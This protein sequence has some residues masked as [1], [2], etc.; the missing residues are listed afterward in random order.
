[1]EGAVRSGSSGHGD[2]HGSSG[3]QRIPQPQSPSHDPEQEIISGGPGA[4]NIDHAAAAAA[5]PGSNSRGMWSIT[6]KTTKEK[7]KKR[8]CCGVRDEKQVEEELVLKA[9]KRRMPDGSDGY[10]LGGGAACAA[11][12]LPASPPP[13][14][15][16]V[17]YYRL[18]SHADALD[19]ALM[20]LG[21]LAAAA[22]GI[23]MPVFLVYLGKLIDSLGSMKAAGGG[24]GT[25]NQVLKV[26]PT[27]HPASCSSCSCR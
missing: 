1:M 26:R 16:S 9:G 27:S 7:R 24:N 20:L 12:H 23:S 25:P 15:P 19:Y 4:T 21:S 6:K 8:K 2:R 3:V 13:P 18:F 17:P 11:A 5:P 22:H 10:A 14:P